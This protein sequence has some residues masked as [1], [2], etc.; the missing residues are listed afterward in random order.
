LTWCKDN[1]VD[2][3]PG[4]PGNKVPDRLVEQ[5]ADAARV[6]LA[7]SQVPVLRRCYGARDE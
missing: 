1:G 3:I 7:P 5:V 6:R 2:Y 4:L